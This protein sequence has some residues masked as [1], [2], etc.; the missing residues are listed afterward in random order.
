MAVTFGRPG[1]RTLWERWT[2]KLEEANAPL[3][4]KLVYNPLKVKRGDFFDI[5]HLEYLGRS[6][7]VV[8]ID[9]WHREIGGEDFYFTEYVLFD[10]T[11]PDESKQKFCL[12]VRQKDGMAGSDPKSLEIMLLTIIAEQEYDPD[13]D[14]NVLPDG[15]V[16]MNEPDGTSVVF[17]RLPE[18]CREPYFCKVTVLEEGKEET[19]EDQ[20]AMWDF[21]REVSP[22]DPK[23]SQSELGYQYLFVEVDQ[24]SGWTMFRRGEEISHVQVRIYPA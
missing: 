9:V 5:S 18:D 14:K 16:Q 19:S 23:D 2:E 17:F 12:R 21:F 15:Q 24:E 20:V 6:F 1:G 4:L 10:Q 7:R 13:L 3:D 11:E 8:E 22:T